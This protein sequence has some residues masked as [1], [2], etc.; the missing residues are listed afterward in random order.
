MSKLY[1]DKHWAIDWVGGT[2]EAGCGALVFLTED[3]GLNWY[4]CGGIM[5]SKG[6]KATTKKGKVDDRELRKFHLTSVYDEQGTD[7]VDADKKVSLTL[8]LFKGYGQRAFGMKPFEAKGG[9]TEVRMVHPVDFLNK[10]NSYRKSGQY[11]KVDAGYQS[12]GPLV[13]Y[14]TPVQGIAGILKSCGEARQVPSTSQQHSDIAQ[15]VITY[16]RQS[17]PGSSDK[18]AKRKQLAT[19]PPQ[20]QGPAATAGTSRSR[21][22][23]LQVVDQ[24]SEEQTETEEDVEFRGRDV[25]SLEDSRHGGVGGDSE[26]NVELEQR[27]GGSGRCD[28]C[29]DEEHNDREQSE[30]G[31]SS[32]GPHNDMEQSERMQ[33][34]DEQDDGG[35]GDVETGGA[36]KSRGKRKA[37]ASLTPAAMKKRAIKEVVDDARCALDASQETLGEATK[38]RKEGSRFRKTSQPKRAACSGFPSQMIQATTLKGWALVGLTSLPRTKRKR[39]SPVRS[40]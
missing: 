32:G 34:E 11:P 35:D 1:R 36:W 31:A 18:A 15:K 7:W 5:K 2:H 17:G 8:A 10:T 37:N 13:P 23:D 6:D 22:T 24:R 19:T 27:P 26:G 3:G 14:D 21:Q 38:K 39:R 29:S 33:N 12:T 30:M 16:S 28:D 4:C 20:L 9:G 40:T 25:G